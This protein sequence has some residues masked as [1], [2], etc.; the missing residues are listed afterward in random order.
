MSSPLS[1]AHGS[2][3]QDGPAPGHPLAPT[4]GPHPKPLPND[5]E[6]LRTI[7]D[8]TKSFTRWA[9]RF[10][11]AHRQL[12]DVLR[13]GEDGRLHLAPGRAASRIAGQYL[14][15]RT[16]L[17]PETSWPILDRLAIGEEERG[18]L[19]IRLMAAFG[20]PG[21]PETE[22]PGDAEALRQSENM[23]RIVD[24]LAKLYDQ[25]QARVFDKLAALA[26]S[27]GARVEVPPPS[28]PPGRR[29]PERG[30]V[31]E[32]PETP[33][34]DRE[35]RTLM[36]KGQVCKKF[37]R[38][39]PRQFQLLDEFQAR[40]WP[41]QL[42]HNPFDQG[43]ISNDEMLVQAIKDINKTLKDR[44]PLGFRYR[45]RRARWFVRESSGG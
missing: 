6:L 35:G 32:Q 26:G 15:S 20:L 39:A 5:L 31:A 10:V 7:L 9:D 22:I 38:H 40:D 19:A 23:A 3:G 30:P 18:E 33:V 45:G 36:Y 41:R 13:E 24:R 11:N 4:H 44:S 1:G 34:W 43:K 14:D 29:C 25:F 17:F 37:G 28:E 16:E 42:P 12:V 21:Y 8:E 2:A 27:D